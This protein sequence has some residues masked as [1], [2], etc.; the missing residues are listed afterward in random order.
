[1]KAHRRH[2]DGTQRRS[3]AVNASLRTSKKREEPFG[4]PDLRYSSLLS[5]RM[6]NEMQS[7]VD[8]ICIRQQSRG[9]VGYLVPVVSGCN[10]S[11]TSGS[12]FI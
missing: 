4:A 6:Q 12:E 10:N 2:G 7:S 11:S 9:I 5:V 1:V 8:H 3:V